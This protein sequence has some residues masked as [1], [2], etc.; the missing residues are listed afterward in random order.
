MQYLL[1]LFLLTSPPEYE[2]FNLYNHITN[3]FKSNFNL[4]SNNKL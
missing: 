1:H 3:Y 4:C 2:I